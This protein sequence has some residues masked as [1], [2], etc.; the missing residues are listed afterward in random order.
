M[1][2]GALAYDYHLL[3][4]SPVYTTWGGPASGYPNYA[5]AAGLSDCLLTN[6][7]PTYGDHGSQ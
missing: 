7:Y 4:G 1:Y 3:G 5:P 6:S 2:N